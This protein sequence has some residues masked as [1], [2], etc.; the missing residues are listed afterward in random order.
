MT[1]LNVIESTPAKSPFKIFT[2]NLTLMK[3]TRAIAQLTTTPQ[4]FFIVP[5]W[6]VNS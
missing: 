3:S 1:K 4:H 5:F 2:S 6:F